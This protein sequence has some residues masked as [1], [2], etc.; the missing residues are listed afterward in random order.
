MNGL[1][2]RY[3]SANE[4]ASDE[5]EIGVSRIKKTVQY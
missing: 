2:K 4:S 5:N 3:D 1:L